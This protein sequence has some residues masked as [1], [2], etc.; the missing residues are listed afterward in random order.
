MRSKIACG[1]YLNIDA[2]IVTNFHYKCTLQ[3]MPLKLHLY[4]KQNKKSPTIILQDDL[5]LKQTSHIQF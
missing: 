3:N 2:N 1:K 5:Y 4:I